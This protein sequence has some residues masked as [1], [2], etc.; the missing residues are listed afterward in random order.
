ML[1][2]CDEYIL[3]I[4]PSIVSIFLKLLFKSRRN[5]TFVENDL[6][7]SCYLMVTSAEPVGHTPSQAP[8]AGTGTQRS[9]VEHHAR[10]H[11]RVFLHC[12]Q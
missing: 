11:W 4:V 1:H 7:L 2:N 8:V 12:G 3:Y 6:L 5:H 10:Q 9:R